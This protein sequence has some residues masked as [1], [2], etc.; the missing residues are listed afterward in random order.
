MFPC[1]RYSHLVLAILSQMDSLF[2]K[3][4]HFL[5]EIIRKYWYFCLWVQHRSP[6]LDAV[7]SL[8]CSLLGV[9]HILSKRIPKRPFA[10]LNCTLTVW[11]CI[12]TSKLITPRKITSL[13]GDSWYFA[14]LW[15]PE[16]TLHRVCSIG[17]WL[18]MVGRKKHDPF[19]VSFKWNQPHWQPQIRI[20]VFAVQDF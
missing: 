8:P 13:E 1:H 15:I 2:L 7:F 18:G 12:S 5:M 19:Q 6:T 4:V 16:S 20:H 10:G 17:T 9:K 11:S 3:N 14:S